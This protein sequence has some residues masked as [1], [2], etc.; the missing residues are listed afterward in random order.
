MA[1]MMDSFKLGLEVIVIMKVIGHDVN[2]EVVFFSKIIQNKFSPFL[3]QSRKQA[4]TR[5]VE[6]PS[7]PVIKVKDEPADD[8]YEQALTSP[9]STASVKDEPNTAKVGYELLNLLLFFLFVFFFKF[10]FRLQL[11]HVDLLE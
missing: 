4:D 1:D 11:K 3:I 9:T 10:I 5:P 2:I 8:E 6:S 7:P